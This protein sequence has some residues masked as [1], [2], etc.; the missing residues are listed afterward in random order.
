MNGNITY[1][2]GA[3]AD[4]ASDVGT[5]AAQL[6]EIHDDIQQRTNAIADFFEGQA[7]TGFH[8]AQMQ[9]LHGFEG[10]IQTVSQHGSTIQSVNEHAAMTDSMMAQGFGA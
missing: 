8:E 9:M 5:R 1:N 7:A 10:L 3:V 2:H 6:L 4:F